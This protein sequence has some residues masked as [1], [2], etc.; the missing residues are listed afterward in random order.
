MCTV[1]QTEAWQMEIVVHLAAV[2]MML[3]QGP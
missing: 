3:V 1:V 2:V